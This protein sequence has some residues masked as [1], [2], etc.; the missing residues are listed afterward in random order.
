MRNT[1]D[2]YKIAVAVLT[3]ASMLDT[4]I[5]LPADDDEREFKYQAW[6][7]VFNH[8]GEIW[9]REALDAVDNHYKSGR[10]AL[11]PRDVVDYVHGLPKD[12][13]RERLQEWILGQ[14]RHP[15]A[16]NVQTMAG[17]E[18]QQTGDIDEA[19]EQYQRWLHE[20]LEQLTDRIMGKWSAGVAKIQ[21]Q[22]VRNSMIDPYGLAEVLPAVE[23]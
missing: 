2:T 13:S 22:P 6:A 7:S 16:Q 20:N 8:A 9:L 15:Y 10:F 1:N 11:M 23:S 17:V 12:S 14:G 19:R 4:R 18:F 5:T 3:K 21:G